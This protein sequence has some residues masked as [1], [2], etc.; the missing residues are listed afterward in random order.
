MSSPGE[1]DGL[2]VAARAALLDALDALDEHRDSVVVIGA[3]AIY[4]RTASAPA[5]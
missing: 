3:Q 1:A 2:L 5:S 4:L